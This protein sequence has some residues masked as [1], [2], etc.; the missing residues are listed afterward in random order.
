MMAPRDDVARKLAPMLKKIR[1]LTRFVT[2]LLAFAVGCLAMLLYIQLRVAHA[3]AMLTGAVPDPTPAPATS[4]LGWEAWLAI[5]LAAF[6]GVRLLIQDAIAV[7]K[8]I[9]PRTETKLDDRAEAFLER[10][11]AYAG[12]IEDAV[13]RVMPAGGGG[14]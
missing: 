1:S 4:G 5:G 6:A 12:R 2:P 13:H 14:K 10:M 8:K 9:A 11:D 3:A 7:L